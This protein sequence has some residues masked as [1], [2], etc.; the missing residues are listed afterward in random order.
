LVSLPILANQ[1]WRYNYYW[2]NCNIKPDWPE[3]HGLPINF[4]IQFGADY[5]NNTQ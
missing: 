4:C 3:I 5:S 1:V 2:N